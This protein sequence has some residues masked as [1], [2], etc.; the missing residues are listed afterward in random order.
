VLPWIE[1]PHLASHLLGGMAKRLSGDWEQAYAHPLY[2]LE[3]FVDPER[4][5]GTWYR[6]AN[7]LG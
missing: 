6:A 7:W 1:V 2:Y 5:Y 3:S 4:F